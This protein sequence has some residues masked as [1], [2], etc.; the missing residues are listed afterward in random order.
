MIFDHRCI[1]HPVL[2]LDKFSGFEDG[3]SGGPRSWWTQWF[4]T[5]GGLWRSHHSSGAAARSNRSPLRL[6]WKAQRSPNAK[7]DQHLTQ[8]PTIKRMPGAVFF[9]EKKHWPLASGP[10]PPSANRPQITG[11]R[12]IIVY[13]F[14]SLPALFVNICRDINCFWVFELAAFLGTKQQW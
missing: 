5:A 4:L 3:I 14:A 8:F 12:Y 1:H 7:L 6:R 10:A 13:L 11:E 2:E 9:N